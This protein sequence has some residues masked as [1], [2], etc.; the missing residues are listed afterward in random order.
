MDGGFLYSVG[1][2]VYA[3]VLYFK[4][5]NQDSC[6]SSNLPIDYD[7]ELDTLAYIPLLQVQ[8][9]PPRIWLHASILKTTSIR[10]QSLE[11]LQKACLL[12]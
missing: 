6:S 12:A 4:P 8:M 11:R 5:A 10:R 3:P 1:F 7:L 2:Q 9:K